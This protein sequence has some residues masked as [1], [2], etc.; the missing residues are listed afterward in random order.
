MSLLPADTN[1]LVNLNILLLFMVSIEPYL[2]NYLLG[3][4]TVEMAQNVS[5][6]YAFDLGG[7]FL[8]QSFFANSLVPQ[9][10][11]GLS[12]KLVRE[13]NFR[14]YNL[15]TGALL[16]FISTIPA[17]WTWSIPLGTNGVV[18][19]RFILMVHSPFLPAFVHLWTR[20][21]RKKEPKHA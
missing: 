21:N 1:T 2:F 18:Q 13:Y 5:V 8:I 9:K 17:F 3:A 15:L 11:R 7:L 14:R 20:R 12:K 19:L 6:V 10:K 4:A 16:F